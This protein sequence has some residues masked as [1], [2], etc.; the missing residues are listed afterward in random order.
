MEFSILKAFDVEVDPATGDV[1]FHPGV[2]F[3]VT[4]GSDIFASH[5]GFISMAGTDPS[6][7]NFAVRVAVWGCAALLR[8]AMYLTCAGFHSCGFKR[9]L[10]AVDASH[11][12]GRVPR[13]WFGVFGLHVL[14]KG[15]RHAMPR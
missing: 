12:P 11:C 8:S 7:G 13:R 9:A 6:L 1:M 5:D 3:T 10:L 4:E 14:A 2:T 15:S